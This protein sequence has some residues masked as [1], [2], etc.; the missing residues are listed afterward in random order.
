MR[1][2]H[3]VTYRG[4]PEA[5]LRQMNK[6]LRGAIERALEYY[7]RK[8]TGLHFKVAA[9]YR[10]DEYQ[11]RKYATVI[12]KRKKHGHNDPLVW[13]GATRDAVL[14]SIRIT[15]RGKTGSGRLNVPGYMFK[16]SRRSGINKIKELQ[17]MNDQELSKLARD[18]A[19]FIAAELNSPTPVVTKRVG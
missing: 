2:R 15:V 4:H 17:A 7:H 16:R 10:Y 19:K 8:Y 14:A 6:T 5:K 1:L 18:M 3:V 11:K 13:T 12:R 9:F